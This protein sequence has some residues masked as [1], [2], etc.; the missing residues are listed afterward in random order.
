M[1]GSEA[2]D[3]IALALPVGID[4]TSDAAPA[5]DGA[6]SKATRRRK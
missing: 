6:P 4:A 3:R 1:V 2:K 5:L